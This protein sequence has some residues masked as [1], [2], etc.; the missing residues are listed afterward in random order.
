MNE[1]PKFDKNHRHELL[2]DSV[3]YD[4]EITK[5]L[6]EKGGNQ[7]NTVS[8]RKTEIFSVPYQKHKHWLIRA[9]FTIQI[10]RGRNTIAA[11]ERVAMRRVILDWIIFASSTALRLGGGWA[12]CA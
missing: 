6:L 11:N 5:F 10:F 3:L 9:N 7:K 1:N 12:D 8:K 4:T 2:F